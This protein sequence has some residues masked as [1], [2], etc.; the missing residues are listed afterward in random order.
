MAYKA[1]GIGSGRSAVMDLFEKE[2]KDDMSFNAAMKLGLKALE[3]AIEEKPTPE[4]TEIGVAE[5]GKKFRRL[6]EDDI[7]ALLK[8]KKP[9]DKA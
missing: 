6:S 9:K 1:T 2:Y 5:E 8:D 3:A 7:S 4:T